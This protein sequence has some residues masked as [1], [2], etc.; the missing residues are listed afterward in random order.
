LQLGQFS[1]LLLLASCAAFAALKNGKSMA[2]GA[3]LALLSIKPHL[4]FLLVPI[5][6]L[7]MWQKKRYDFFLGGGIVMLAW[8]ATTLW[9][10]PSSLTNWWNFIHSGTPM[11]WVGSNLPALLRLGIFAAS[12]HLPQWPNLVVPGTALLVVFM[13]YGLRLD[14]IEWSRDFPLLIGLSVFLSPYGH[15][16][17]QLLLLPLYWQLIQSLHCTAERWRKISTVIVLAST[18]IFWLL[19][20]TFFS[21]ELHHLAWLPPILLAVWAGRRPWQFFR[22]Y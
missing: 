1:A 13:V 3:W 2:C 8:I 6:G 19:Q 16:Y 9:L 12:G 7:W 15:P 11:D 22:N 20:L 4:F 10:S 21:R 18:Q 14:K 17:D 5:L